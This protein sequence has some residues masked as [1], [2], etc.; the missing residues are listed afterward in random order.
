MQRKNSHKCYLF[1]TNK[2]TYFFGE[3]VTENG[4]LVIVSVITQT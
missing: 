1:K 3:K 2:L 4:V